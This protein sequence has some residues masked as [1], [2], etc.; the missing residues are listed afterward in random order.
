M[1]KRRISWNSFSYWLLGPCFQQT[2]LDLPQFPCSTKTLT[3]KSSQI[4]VNRTNLLLKLL[5]GR[6]NAVTMTLSGPHFLESTTGLNLNPLTQPWAK[7]ILHK[8]H[9]NVTC[10]SSGLNNREIGKGKRLY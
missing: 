2:A 1:V 10:G 9:T 3:I 6:N 5:T 7:I 4:K 8:I